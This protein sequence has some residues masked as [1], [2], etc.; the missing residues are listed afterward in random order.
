M[1]LFKKFDGGEDISSSSAVKSSVIRGIRS[2]L[3][4]QYPKIE[5]ILNELL[6]PK[7]GAITIAKCS[8]KIQLICHNGSVLFFQ[9]RV[10][11]HHKHYLNIICAWWALRLQDDRYSCW[12]GWVGLGR[13]TP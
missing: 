2:T 4:K 5:N 12:L 7:G 13:C 6:P 11:S 9:E 3:L 8:G 1:A 10:S